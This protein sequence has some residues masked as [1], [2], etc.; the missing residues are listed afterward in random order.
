M[1]ELVETY[2]DLPLVTSVGPG[3]RPFAEWP[4]VPVFRVWS[5]GAVAEPPEWLT[6]NVASVA[7]PYADGYLTKTV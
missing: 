1:A 6:V 5:T 7:A 4:H 2:Q 3:E